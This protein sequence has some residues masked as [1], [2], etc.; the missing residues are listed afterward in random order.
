MTK[1]KD[2]P[3]QKRI[4]LKGFIETKPHLAMLKEHAR[5]HGYIS[6]LHLMHNPH[7]QRIHSHFLQLLNP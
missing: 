1:Y 2:I 6:A 4:A 3:L 7:F 5:K